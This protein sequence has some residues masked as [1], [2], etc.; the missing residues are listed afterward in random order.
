[1]QRAPQDPAD[2]PPAPRR[3]PR[4][5]RL[6]TRVAWFIGL[7]V[8]GVVAVGAAGLVIRALLK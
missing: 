8:S 1:M 2:R 4:P 3:T 7:W 5:A 6:R